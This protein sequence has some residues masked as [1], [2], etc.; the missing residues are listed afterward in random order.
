MNCSIRKRSGSGGELLQVIGPHG[1]SE[2]VLPHDGSLRDE[3]AGLTPV[4][5]VCSASHSSPPLSEMEQQILNLLAQKDYVPANV[6]ELLRLLQ[7][8]PNHQQEL[9]AVLQKNGASR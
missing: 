9:Q 7:L 6:P 3:T 8:S 5:A 2:L 4:N 1:Q